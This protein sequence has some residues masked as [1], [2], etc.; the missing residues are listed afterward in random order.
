MAGSTPG[1]VTSSSQGLIWVFVGF[2]SCSRV[3]QQ[4]SKGVFAPSPTN[5]TLPGFLTALN[6]EPSTSQASSQQKATTGAQSYLPLYNNH[7]ALLLE[8][9]CTKK[10][11]WQFSEGPHL[12]L[13]STTSNRKINIAQP[14][15]TRWQQVKNLQGP[16]HIKSVS[17][18]VA[19][20]FE[21][22]RWIAMLTHESMLI[23]IMWGLLIPNINSIGL[24]DAFWSKLET[25][26]LL[27]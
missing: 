4:C 9:G 23:L 13:R 16:F 5:R 27:N 10:R 15:W 8:I 6:R 11:P 12:I 14:P 18:T 26:N 7:D 22:N 1:S 25:N 20:E 17:M 21:K 3:P 2:V 19:Q 24:K